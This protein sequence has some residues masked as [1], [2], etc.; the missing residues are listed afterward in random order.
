MR[1]KGGD[2]RGGSLHQ[3]ELIWKSSEEEKV[4]GVTGMQAGLYNPL[5]KV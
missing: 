1:K 4:D 5:K 2:I 3:K